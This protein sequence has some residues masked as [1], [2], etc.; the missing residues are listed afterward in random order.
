MGKSRIDQ[1]EMTRYARHLSLPGWG[2]EG[3]KKLKKSSVLIV[4]V[5]GLGTVASLYL[6]AAGVGRIGLVDKD[7]VSLNNLHRQILFS[8][9]DIGQSK[10]PLVEKR[11]KEHNPHVQIQTH[12]SFL[13]KEN[14]ARMIGDYEIVIDGTDNFTA[15]LI[16]NEFCAKFDKPYIYGAVNGFDGQLSVFRATDGP[17]FRC[18]F[19]EPLRSKT[20][21]ISAHSS[22]LNTVPAIIGTLQATQALKLILGVGEPLVGQLLIFNALTLSLNFYEIL[23]KE[24]CQTCGSKD[25]SVIGESWRF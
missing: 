9:K 23:K 12:P 24:Q 13:T 10:I 18:L 5:G 19:P 7:M 1:I 20:E 21:P 2:I 3:Q 17:C 11:L 16:I 15:R 25:D 6:A 22:I 4:G 8:T 14:A